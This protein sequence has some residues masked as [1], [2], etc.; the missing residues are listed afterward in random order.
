MTTALERGEGSAS[1]LGRSLPPGKMRYTMYRRLG[2]PQARS[3]QMRKNS[4]QPGIGSPDRPARNQSLYR[5][6]YPGPIYLLVIPFKPLK[7]R[8]HLTWWWSKNETCRSDIY[9]YCTE[10]FHGFKI[11]SALVGE[12]TV[13]RIRSL[14]KVHLIIQICKEN[15]NNRELMKAGTQTWIYTSLYGMGQ[16]YWRIT[17]LVFI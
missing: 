12:W 8:R 3:G 11:N 16:S 10:Q 2:G 4:P 14:R 5:L 1:R 13:H 6:S 17:A 15:F 7:Y 9:V